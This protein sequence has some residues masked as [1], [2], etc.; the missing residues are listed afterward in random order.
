MKERERAFTKSR[1]KKNNKMQTVVKNSPISC[2][3]IGGM[4]R[5]RF[6][7]RLL[8]EPHFQ[9]YCG[10][11]LEVSQIVRDALFES[12]QDDPAIKERS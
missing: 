10:V 3:I 8:L 12:I 5:M 6:R 11:H 9:I 2:M 7:R 1:G 4:R